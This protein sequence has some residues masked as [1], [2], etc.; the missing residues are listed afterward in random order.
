MQKLAFVAVA[1][2]A[3]LSLAAP[4]AAAQSAVTLAAKE[5]GCTAPAVFCFDKATAPI[6]PGQVTI[7]LQNPS[8]NTAPH[9]ICVKVG[10]AAD[11]CAPAK[12]QYV[13]VGNTT[14]LTFTA[15]ASGEVTYW[16]EP[17]KT[18]GMTGRFTVQGAAPPSPPPSGNPPASPPPSTPPS[19]SGTKGSPSVG[20]VAIALGVGLL[21]VAMRRR[22]A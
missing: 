1:L 7:T 19:D 13:E 8:P 5:Q 16:C 20:M 6:S 3:A 10:T 9:N 22:N 21:A 4:L 18:I 17:H 2:V 11:Q 15:P 12:D 14:T